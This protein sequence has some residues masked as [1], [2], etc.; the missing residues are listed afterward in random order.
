MNKEAT[1]AREDWRDRDD[2]RRRERARDDFGLADYSDDYVYD[3][4]RRAGYRAEEEYRASLEDYG[5]ADYARDPAYDPDG[6]RA[7]RRRAEADREY[8]RRMDE[9]DYRE[10]GEPRSWLDRA[11]EFFTGHPHRDRDRDLRRDGDLRR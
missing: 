11:E 3:P 7:Y 9:G 10:R 1:M 6:R 5:Q 8:G 4:D 2:M